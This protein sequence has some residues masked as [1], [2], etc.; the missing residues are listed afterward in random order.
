[1]RRLILIFAMLL[2][3]STLSGGPGVIDEILARNSGQL[4]I[5]VCSNSEEEL[6]VTL[7]GSGGHTVYLE[8]FPYQCKPVFLWSSEDGYEVDWRKRY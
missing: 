2:L 1:M 3:T 5:K 6:V 4:L 7:R 8:L